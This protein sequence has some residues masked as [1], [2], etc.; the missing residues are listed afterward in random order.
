MALIVANSAPLP[1]SVSGTNPTAYGSLL[2]GTN[3]VTSGPQ[4]VKLFSS[5]INA[6]GTLRMDGSQ[7]I[8]RASG[9]ITGG[10]STNTQFSLY[11]NYP[12]LASG[13]LQYPTANITAAVTINSAGTNGPALFNSNNNF[14]LGQYVS[15]NLSP[16]LQFQ[17]IVGPLTVANSTAFAGLI[18]GANV[19]NASTGLTVNTST[20]ALATMLPQPLYSGLNLVSNLN[21]GQVVPFMSEVRIAGDQE[22][23]LVFAFGIDGVINYNGVGAGTAAQSLNNPAVWVVQ[24]NI[25]NGQCVPGVN[26]K[27]E[28]PF[29]LQAGFTFGASSASNSSTLKA[30]FLE[31]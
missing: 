4:P 28:P 18:N 26:F 25:G 13:G 21:V 12:T 17:G 8:V 9:N 27:N 6:P 24:Q 3:G 2:P 1:N 11:L 5:L 20:T 30:F 31:Q 29:T 23:N 22:S 15:V 7:G 16:N 19:V 14:V 10:V